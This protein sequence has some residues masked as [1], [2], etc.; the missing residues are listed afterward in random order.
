MKAR[1]YKSSLRNKDEKL[2]FLGDYE[3]FA[4]KY[5]VETGNS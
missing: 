5:V 3:K 2:S 1:D 4:K